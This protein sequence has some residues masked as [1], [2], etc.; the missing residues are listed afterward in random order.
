MDRP[1][2]LAEQLASGDRRALARAITLVE[3]TRPD[4]R[5]AARELLAGLEVVAEP[6]GARLEHGERVDVGLVRGG[7]GAPGRERDLDVVAGEPRQGDYQFAVNNSFGF[8]GHNVAI[9]F[10]KY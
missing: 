6:V 7:V 5:R 2:G 4:H 3:S 8:G 1:A 10:G 9:A